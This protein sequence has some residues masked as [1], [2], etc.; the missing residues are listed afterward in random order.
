MGGELQ[1]IWVKRMKR[2]P[3]DALAKVACVAGR[4]LAGNANQ[5]GRRQVTIFSKETWARAT[6]AFPV[7]PPPQVRRANLLVSGA[8]LAYSRGKVLHVGS[9]RIRILGETRPCEQMDEACP[10]LRAALEE[11]WAGGAFGEVLD[12]GEI[13]VGATVTL[14]E[15]EPNP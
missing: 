4:G 11:P 14:L 13:Q 9:V 10:G 1:A 7:P 5:G 12:D 2:G 8:D 15:A 3:M 6:A